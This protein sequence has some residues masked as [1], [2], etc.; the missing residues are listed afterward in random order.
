MDPRYTGE[1]L[2]HLEK[3][4]ELLTSAYN[5]MSHELH[6][7]QVE[8]EMLM[9]KFYDLMA[10]QGLSKKKEGSNNVSDGGRTGQSTASLPNT[11]DISD[12]GIDRH[13]SAVVPFTATDEQM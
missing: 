2:K 1:I 4:N 13:P 5:S 9:R 12:G 8:E 7:L 3:Q 11:V 6:K 10:A